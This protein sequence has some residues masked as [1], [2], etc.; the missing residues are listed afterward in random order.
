VSSI[1]LTAYGSSAGGTYAHF[2]LLVDGK[3]VGQATT[4]STKKAYTF[5]VD[6]DPSRAHAI[7]IEFDNDTVIGGADRNLFVSSLQ[8]DG[9]NLALT[10]EGARYLVGSAG[11]QVPRAYTGAMPWNG[12][13]VVDVPSTVAP[14]PPPP[15]PPPVTNG[16]LKLKVSGDSWNGAPQFVVL[17]DGKQIGGTQTT[18]ARHASGEWQEITLTGVGSTPGKVEVKFL[19]DA[20]GG[21]GKD[22]NLYVGAIE[23]N[24][25]RYEG[26]AA[27]NTASNGQKDAA[28]AVMATNGS[29]IFTMA[30]PAPEAPSTTPP[31]PTPI[32]VSSG[33]SR[34]LA[35]SEQHLVLTGEG[36]ING[37]GNALENRLTGN[38]AANVLDGG[39]GADDMLGGKGND[40]YVVENVGDKVTEL[41]NEGLDTVQASVNYALGANVENLILTG[42]AAI[43]GTGNA[44][45]NKIVGNA[46]N[47]VLAGGAGAD[48]LDGGAGNDRLIGGTGNDRLEGGAGEDTAVLTGV[49]ADYRVTTSNGVATI[50]ALKGTDGTDTLT[51][52]EKL[53]FADKTLDIGAAVTP[54][55]GTVN[56]ARYNGT[57]RTT[58]DGQV[59]ENLDIYSGGTGIEVMHKNVII[60]NVRVHHADGDGI[61]ATD[62]NNL[63]IEKVEVVNTDPPAGQQ[64]EEAEY[65]NIELVR[66][67]DVTIR[68][69]TVREGSTGI[70][71][72]QSP[73]AEID[74]VDGYDFH[75]P[76]PRGQFVQFNQSPDGSLT[77]FYTKSVGAE[78][79]VEDNVSVY[80]SA[81][82]HIENGVIDGNSSRTGVG[83]MV[84]D[85]SAGTVV[86]NVDVIHQG[87]GGFS[88]YTDD[89]TF[90]DVRTFDSFNYDQ[91]RGAPSSNGIQFV[92]NGHGVV[93]DDATYTRPGNPG[94]IVWQPIKPELLDVRHDPNAVAMSHEPFVNDWHWVN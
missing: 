29:L 40:T 25:K 9:R 42:S 5:N 17:V 89:V 3:V 70:Y 31:A 30:A 36:A 88:A 61:R 46:A 66:S 32:A 8:L 19:N 93:F 24:G 44:L 49:F 39:A 94:N 60:R 21:A 26:E 84:E 63:L 48:N 34:T 16:T 10:G 65:N 80:A 37:T 45:D 14:P 38:T 28:A 57:M 68:N 77:N 27:A 41:A 75:G 71:L 79:H 13:L 55:G 15:P 53:A 33:A 62:A 74:H 92:V 67:A 69:V 6:L 91:G 73:R 11:S 86:K 43:S 18:T 4:S 51:G 90:I 1:S 35:A 12:A 56:L 20:W 54:E 22:R 52:I 58:H 81:R 47:N 23:L 72:V 59:I 78:S 76:F 50:A 85:G 7:S 2:K 87:N 64:G 82:T 83:V